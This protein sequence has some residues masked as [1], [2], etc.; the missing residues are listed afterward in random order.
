MFPNWLYAV[1][2]AARCQPRRPF[3]SIYPKSLS[4]SLP[5]YIT[6]NQEAFGAARLVKAPDGVGALLVVMVHLCAVSHVSNQPEA[7]LPD[8]YLRNNLANPNSP[9]RASWPSLQTP[10]SPQGDRTEKAETW[11]RRDGPPP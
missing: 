1:P 5:S 2:L 4:N 6:R 8:E 10:P 9:T 3:W 7:R 11:L